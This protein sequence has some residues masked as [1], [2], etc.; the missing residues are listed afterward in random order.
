MAYLFVICLY[1]LVPTIVGEL[2]ESTSELYIY[3]FCLTDVV[4][5]TVFLLEIHSFISPETIMFC[6]L[7]PWYHMSKSETL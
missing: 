7:K 2:Y 3:V 6:K 1:C 5:V 4:Q